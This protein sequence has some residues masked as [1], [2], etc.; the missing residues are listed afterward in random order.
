MKR[1]KMP[2]GAISD[3]KSRLYKGDTHV[4][5]NGAVIKVLKVLKRTVE[6]DISDEAIADFLEDMEYQ[7]EFS[8]GAY[9]SACRHGHKKMKQNLS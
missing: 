4:D 5:R 3:H 6:I 8:E 7:I 1:M 9:K 2:L